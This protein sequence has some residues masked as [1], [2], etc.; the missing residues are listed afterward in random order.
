[1]QEHCSPTSAVV[2]QPHLALPQAWTP[3]THRWWPPHFRAAVRTLLLVAAR[4]R[5]QVKPAGP[6]GAPLTRRRAAAA[7]ATGPSQLLAQLEPELL[8]G[9][10]PHAAFPLSAWDWRSYG[11][12]EGNFYPKASLGSDSD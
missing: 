7:A 10:V 1:M 9:I 2:R 8:R 5:W 4:G 6:A 12:V 11:R 3:D